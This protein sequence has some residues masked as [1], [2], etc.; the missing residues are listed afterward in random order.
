MAGITVK[1]HVEAPPE[2]VFEVASDFAKAPEHI[3]GIAKVEMLTDGPVGAGTRFRETRIMFKREA[4]EEME[5]TA[6]DPPRSYALGCE[7]HGC[8]YHSVLTFTP[9]G[10]GTDVEMTFEA[11]PLT[12][13]AKVMSVAMSPMIKKVAV[14]CSKDLDDLKAA[15]ESG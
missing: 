15:V 2:K 12:V 10:D 3:R 11:T 8:K 1:K 5:V 7:N 14:E 4:T 9:N 6:F 13:F